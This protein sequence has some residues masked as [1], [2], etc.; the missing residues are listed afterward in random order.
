MKNNNKWFSII[1]ALGLV[2][3]INLIAIN[4]LDYIIPFWKETKNIE[5]SVVS[6]YQ[7]DSAVEEALFYLKKNDFKAWTEWSYSNWTVIAKNY[8]ITA[9]WSVL[10]KAW[11]WNSEYDKNWD[12]LSIWNPIQLEI[13][14]NN[15]LFTNALF[16]FRVPKINSLAN[17]TLSWT[18]V[19][20]IINWQISSQNNTLNASSWTYIFSNK[21]LSNLICSSSQNFTD[22]DLNINTFD[23]IDLDWNLIQIWNYY[24][25]NC[26][27]VWSWCILKFSI[28]NKIETPSW[29]KIPYLEWR[30][31][32]WTKK[33]PL[34]YSIIETSW[35]S[36]WY[37]KDLKVK[38]PQQSTNEAF[39]FTVFQ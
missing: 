22:C 13:W 39:D 30:F 12:T 34:K 4:I 16:A 36:Y 23:W 8:N 7:A 10:P 31:D 9:S 38:I 27:W 32:F 17:L 25:S 37:K 20:P 6:Y 19:L 15:V 28:V 1:I 14:Y 35:K 29:I 2:V 33:P 18:S 26:I 21:S 11:E 5:N 3:L 24:N